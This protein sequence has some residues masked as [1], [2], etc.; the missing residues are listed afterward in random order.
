MEV[1]KY[2]I[3]YYQVQTDAVLG[4]LV[5]TDLQ[6][7]A[8]DIRSLKSE[9]SAYVQKIYKKN[10][11][12]PWMDMVD[13]TLK[14]V[15]IDILPAY[16]DQYGSYPLSDMVKVPVPFIYGE[17]QLGHYECYL[18]L[19]QNS[20]Y[21]YDTK[22]FDSLVQ[23]YGQFILNALQP[24]EIY[25]LMNYPKPEID[26]ISIKVPKEKDYDYRYNN[27]P[28]PEMLNRLA[29]KYPLSRG[30]QKSISNS[31]DA[32]WELED[33]VDEVI[34]KIVNMQANVLLVG[35]HGVGKSAVFR[36]AIR[37]I[38]SFTRNMETGFQF[39][40]IQ[41]QRITASTRYLGEW[42]Q[43]CEKIV[44]E[45]QSINGILWMEDII[46]LLELGG[47]GAEDS[48]AAFL[49]SFMQQGKLQLIG[50][51]TPQELES[52]RRLLPGFAECF[53]TIRID[54]L[55]ESKT[56]SIIQHFAS[57]ALQNLHIQVSKEA[58]QTVFQLMQRYYP[59]E[60]FPGKAL[61]FLGKSISDSQ[62]NHETY[63]GKKE[64][65]RQFV[66]QTGFPELFLND[67]ILLDVN[68]LE[69]FFST[70]IIGQPRACKRLSSLVKIFKAGLNSPGKPIAT[71][72]FAGPTGVGKTA[73]AK[74]LADYFFGKGQNRS[75]LVRIDMSEFQYSEQIDRLIGSGKEV[76]QLVQLIRERP[77]SVL[78]LDEVEK[79]DPSIFDILL[80]V[81]DEGQMVDALGRVTHFRNTI[82]I[83][84]TNLGAGNK[85]AIGF[86]ATTSAEDLYQSALAAYFRPEFINRI[87]GTV[88][89]NSLTKED[90]L[91]ITRKELGEIRNREGFLKRGIELQFTERLIQQIADAG[92]DERYGARPLQRTIEMSIINPMAYWLLDHPETHDCRLELDFDDKLL[93][94]AL[95]GK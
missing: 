23:H 43:N 93:V 21:Y 5:G 9:F 55:E 3:L 35:N 73:A 68:E 22:Q 47:D 34:D 53:Q 92:F 65:I 61:K 36:Q 44:E 94:K 78:L 24:H 40:Q 28:E 32:A 20:F 82:I 10:E 74:A 77:F 85:N 56:M 64:V 54:E 62:L 95:T 69:T 79:A 84:T 37:K 80:T 46:R 38:V 81:L 75:P 42:Q 66:Q 25:Q 60:Q 13:I 70:Q 33:K 57:Y 41:P 91:L 90:I 83:L 4:F 89:F 7:L 16:K 45:L 6:L 71:L 2:P 18:P 63:I 29:G 27:A 88:V 67:E 52:M 17:T 8:K 59:Y 11:Y 14:V 51:V 30:M 76:G 50:E 19:F 58:Q 1:I 48:V 72:I 31:P 26:L 15:E 12:F 39:W 86:K 49:Q 87:D